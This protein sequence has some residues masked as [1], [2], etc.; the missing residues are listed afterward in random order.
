EPAAF[1]PELRLFDDQVSYGDQVAHFAKLWRHVGRFVEGFDLLMQEVQP[2][3]CALQTNVRTDDAD[4]VA[5]QELQ[6][7]EALGEQDHFPRFCRAFGVPVRYA[8]L[9]GY[10]V[11]LFHTVHIT[12][13][14]EYERFQQRVAC[15]AVG[16][17]QTGGG[18][19]PASIEVAD[20]GAAPLV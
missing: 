1:F 12:T 6:L 14:A 11:C 3:A 16:P 17:M 2:L 18:A 5:H 20:R 13:M 19:F 10:P 15:Q 8:A 4:I 7:F 9:E